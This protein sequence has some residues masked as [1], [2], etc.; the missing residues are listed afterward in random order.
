VQPGG[1]V[2]GHL[3]H[4]PGQGGDDRGEGLRAAGSED[5]LQDAEFHRDIPLH[6]QVAMRDRGQHPVQVSEHR[7][8]VGV[9]QQLPLLRDYI[10]GDRGERRGVLDLEADTG[11]D[12][13]L[14]AEPGEGLV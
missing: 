1:N 7:P 3:V 10:A 2:G 6:G 9:Q 14:T 11:R 4:A 12:D 13:T 5:V 8:F